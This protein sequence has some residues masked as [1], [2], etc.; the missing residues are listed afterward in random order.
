MVLINKKSIIDIHTKKKKIPN[1]TLK[2]AGQ[3]HLTQNL[4]YNKVLNISCNFLNTVQKVKN[5]M[6]VWV[7]NGC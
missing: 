7:Q 6:D 3:N 5:R 4:M 2:I 1:T